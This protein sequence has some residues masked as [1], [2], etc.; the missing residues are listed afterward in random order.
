MRRTPK[1]LP[2]P[3]PP[4]PLRPAA[5]S[6][7]GQEV[8]GAPDRIIFRRAGPRARPFASKEVQPMWL[9]VPL[10]NPGDCLHRHPAQPGAA[11][12]HALDAD[13][14]RRPRDRSAGC[15]TG[16][17]YELT[18]AFQA[19]VPGT[20]MNL[21]GQACAEAA[22]AAGWSDPQG[23]ADAI[24]LYDGGQGSAPGPGPAPAAVPAPGGFRRQRWAATTPPCP[25]RCFGDHG[26][27]ASLAGGQRRASG[28]A[29]PGHRPLHQRPLV[30]FVPSGGQS[31][32]DGPEWDPMI[33]STPC[34]TADALR[35]AV[36]GTLLAG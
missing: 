5:P 17:L 3:R 14:L 18:G 21:S 23:S 34:W 29:A 15:G 25:V 19:L 13:A 35:L 33:Q 6:R 4:P 8:A 26:I 16:T 32:T 20:Y 9:L 2:P 1:P 22:A 30:D 10:G 7:Q 31:W 28:P 36:H 11:D 27:W 24:L 12:A